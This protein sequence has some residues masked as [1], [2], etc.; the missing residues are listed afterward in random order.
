MT[1]CTNCG[2]VDDFEPLKE[3]CSFHDDNC[4]II[5]RSLYFRKYYLSKL[6][7]K[8]TKKYNISTKNKNRIIPDLEKISNVLPLI[9]GN[10]RWMININFIMTL[11][12]MQ[13]S[14]DNIKIT[15]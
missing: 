3:F 5:V 1:V 2:K 8:L 4:K 12:N 14:I 15:K 11:N 10:R 13:I 6:K 7:F 9:N